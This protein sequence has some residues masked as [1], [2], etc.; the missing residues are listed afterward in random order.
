MIEQSSG[1]RRVAVLTFT[2]LLMLVAVGAGVGPAAAQSPASNSHSSLTHSRDTALY[3]FPAN[4]KVFPEG[5]AYHPGTG[6]FFVSSF[7][8]GAIYRG[9][10]KPRSGRRMLTPFLEAG[11]DGRTV[12]LGMKV[13]P[14]GRLW[15][16]GG[17]TGKIWLYDAVTGK[18]LVSFYNGVEGTFVN[19]V[20]LAPDGAAYVTDSFRPYVYRIMT[21]DQGHLQYELWH[22]L[23]DTAILY[24]DGFNLNGIA[25]TDDGKYLL[26]IQS[27]TGKLFRIATESKEVTEIEL[28]GGDRMT[29]GDGLWLEGHMLYVARNDLNLVVQLQLAPDFASGVQ[30]G[31][32]TDP[33]FD[34]I[35]TIAKIG[36]RLLLPNFQVDKLFSG[37]APT[38]PFTVSSVVIP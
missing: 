34:R 23:S 14:K 27:N 25:V 5:I 13:D 6:D 1:L 16:A 24:E 3:S 21:D 22:D 7:A 11:V 17:P 26:V 2:L 8:D 18:L 12:A 9:S 4:A 36:N 30:I 19:D 29:F 10:V 28:L 37:D 33:S 32:F 20:A 38:L 31:S 35:S 15:I